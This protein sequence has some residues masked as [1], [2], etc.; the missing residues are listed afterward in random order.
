MSDDRDYRARWL[1]SDY[2]AERYRR[3][4]NEA[5]VTLTR[6][7]KATFRADLTMRD[8]RAMAQETRLVIE[9]FRWDEAQRAADRR[10]T[11][12]SQQPPPTHVEE[13]TDD[14]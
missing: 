4:L 12:G 6:I 1:A 8:V 14:T 2:E 10:V 5:H 11:H 3:M 7:E 9:S 13:E